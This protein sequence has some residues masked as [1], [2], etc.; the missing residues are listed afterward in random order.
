MDETEHE[1]EMSTELPLDSMSTAEK[2]KVM[3]A[4]WASLRDAPDLP[5]PE[6]HRELL[7]ERKRRL[8]SGEA[9]LSSWDEAKR[10]LNE[11]GNDH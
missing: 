4:V 2:L 8:E 6:W 9:T 7:A 5:T 10:R 11:L 3:E 1:V